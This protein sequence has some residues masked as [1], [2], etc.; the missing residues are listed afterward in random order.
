VKGGVGGDARG[1]EE[2]SAGCSKG[3][4]ASLLEGVD[5]HVEC[6]LMGWHFSHSTWT[7]KTRCAQTSRLF[8]DVIVDMTALPLKA[9]L[10]TPHTKATILSP[11]PTLST[12]RCKHVPAAN[13]ALGMCG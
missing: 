11:D 1:V 10:D 3:D 6:L 4:A 8:I 2:G 7:E 13:I 12:A 5:A 9:A